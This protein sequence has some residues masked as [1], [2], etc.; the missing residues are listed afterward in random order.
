MASWPKTRFPAVAALVASLAFLLAGCGGDDS[1]ASTATVRATAAS[2]PSAKASGVP[3]A[4]AYEAMAAALQKAT[5]PQELIDGTS[6]GKK[7]AKVVIQAYED[8]TCPHCL[9]FSANQEPGLI[10]QFVKSGLVRFEFKYFP[11][12]QSSVGI[13]IGAQCAADQNRFWEYQR[14]L[15]IS[16][17]NADGKPDDQ[18]SQAM[19]DAFGQDG[20][21]RT[22]TTAGLDVAKFNGC[23]A[24][25]QAAIDRIQA[26]Y[27]EATKV[28][29][30]GTPAFVINGQ[31]QS[32]GYPANIDGWK[33]LIDGYAK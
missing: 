24:N 18:Y 12:R 21:V 26:D 6:I 8:F 16:Q 27:S 9:D 28:K 30:N 2:S 11:L 3:G 1:S 23:L 32:S 33:K 15:F 17:A 4:A 19:T 10:D 20:L 13:M 29:I 25:P 7:D 14:L 22:A 5:Y 31:F